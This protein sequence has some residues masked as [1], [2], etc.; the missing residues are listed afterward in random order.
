MESKS[1]QTLTS[2]HFPPLELWTTWNP[3]NWSKKK[4]DIDQQLKN[5]IKIFSKRQQWDKI[6]F[7]KNRAPPQMTKPFT[8]PTEKGSKNENL[9]A[10]NKSPKFE[11]KRFFPPF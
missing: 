11:L 2:F 5:Y 8:F 3:L 10:N 4:S 1:Q 7:Q 9:P 6:E